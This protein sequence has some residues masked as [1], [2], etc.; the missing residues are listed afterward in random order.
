MMWTGTSLPHSNADGLELG[1]LSI[2]DVHVSDIA[3]APFLL[4][5]FGETIKKNILIIPTFDIHANKHYTHTNIRVKSGVS[6]WAWTHFPH[7]KAQCEL[8]YAFKTHI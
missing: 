3:K 4:I 2:R 1:T 5:A 7:S 8:A 6:T